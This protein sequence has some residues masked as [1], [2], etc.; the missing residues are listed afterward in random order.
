MIFGRLWSFIFC[1][2]IDKIGITKKIRYSTNLFIRYKNMLKIWSEF[3]LGFIPKKNFRTL[4]VGPHKFLGSLSC[5]C[6]L[7]EDVMLP[8]NTAPDRGPQDKNA[9]FNNDFRRPWRDLHKTLT[10]PSRDLHET[11]TRPLRDV[12]CMFLP[13]SFYV[14]STFKLLIS[15]KV[16]Q[17]YQVGIRLSCPTISAE[18]SL[19]FI[20]LRAS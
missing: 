13:C 20:D 17:R 8:Q 18:V 5:C 3:S 14:P 1:A 12:P 15:L 11:F 19:Q 9:L 4:P 10:K 16:M 2:S 7:D 6:I